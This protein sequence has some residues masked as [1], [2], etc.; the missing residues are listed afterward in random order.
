MARDPRVLGMVLAGGEGKRL[1]PLTADRAKPAVPFGGN[2][3]LIDFA[4]SNIVNAG[5]GTLTFGGGFILVPALVYL[6]RVPGNVVLGTS[7]LQ[8]VAMMSATMILHAINSQSVDI[9]LGFCLTYYDRVNRKHRQT[10]RRLRLTSL[11]SLASIEIPDK[12]ISE[13]LSSIEEAIE[14]L[15]R[16]GVIPGVKLQKP[17]DWHD[18]LAKRNTRAI[19]AVELQAHRAML[20]PSQFAKRIRTWNIGFW[21]ARDFRCRC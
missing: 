11:L 17:T 2:Y 8:V 18:M 6:L 13:F 10:E 4:L 21:G 20:C 5:T 12:R 14:D 3:R 15:S 9:L 7:L 19:I 16:D 1:W